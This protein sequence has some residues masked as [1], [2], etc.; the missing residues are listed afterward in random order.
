MTGLTR[1]RG[2][3]ENG[4]FD[5]ERLAAVATKMAGDSPMGFIVEPVDSAQAILWLASPAARGVTGHVIR[6]NAGATMA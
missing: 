1:L 5:E 2:L 3:D 4:V 6:T